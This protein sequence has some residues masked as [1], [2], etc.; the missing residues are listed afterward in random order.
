MIQRRA[1]CIDV[2]LRAGAQI[3]NLFKR[4]VPRRVTKNA[5]ASCATGR[6]TGLR[7][8]QAEVEKNYASVR[9]DLQ[10]V[11][12]DIAMNNLPLVRVE[13]NQRIKY[14]VSPGNYGVSRK[15]PGLLGNHLSQVLTFN[16]LHHQKSAIAFGKVVANPR[17]N[18]MIQPGHQARL[19][20]EL[21]PQLRVTCERLFQRHG[22]TEP[23]VDGFINGA[24][25]AFAEVANDLIATLQDG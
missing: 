11:R 18:E 8:C 7:L 2:A 24:H 14:L 20:L 19:A 4:R 9:S 6:V 17:Q 10:I 12:F 16:K 13:I 15:W 1:Q 3:L 25:P 22:V 5:G 23:E 21:F